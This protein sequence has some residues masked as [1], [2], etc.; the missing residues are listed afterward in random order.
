MSFTPEQELFLSEKFTQLN[1]R[2]KVITTSQVQL[3]DVIKSINNR[4]ENLELKVDKLHKD[5]V[6]EIES[7]LDEISKD[8]QNIDKATGFKGMA[9]NVDSITTKEVN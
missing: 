5:Q 7:K 2:I 3:I 4:L 6:P 1:D 9:H 8:I